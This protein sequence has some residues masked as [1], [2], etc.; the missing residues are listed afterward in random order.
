MFSI[1]DVCSNR[2]LFETFRGEIL[3]APAFSLA[4]AVEREKS[5]PP[6]AN[7]KGQSAGND[8]QP[9]SGDSSY[10]LCH[11]DS[12][13]IGNNNFWRI[14]FTGIGI[15]TGIMYRVFYFLN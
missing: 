2:Q 3:S 1:I 9:V 15:G 12:G 10:D 6:T 7:N 13:I 8:C 11:V 4:V 14:F 5:P